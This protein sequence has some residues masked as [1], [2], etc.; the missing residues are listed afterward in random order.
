MADYCR[1]IAQDYNTGYILTKVQLELLLEQNKQLN[2]N[3]LRRIID[4]LWRSSIFYSIVKL[5]ARKYPDETLEMTKILLAKICEQNGIEIE[6]S[7][8]EIELQKKIELLAIEDDR[9]EEEEETN[10]TMLLEENRKSQ[11]EE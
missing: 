7:K 5:D 6:W 11:D 2:K 10:T 3:K 4:E 8:E 1:L 9:T